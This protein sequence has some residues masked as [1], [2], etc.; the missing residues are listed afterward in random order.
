M[1]FTIDNDLLSNPKHAVNFFALLGCASIYTHVN[2]NVKSVVTGVLPNGNHVRYME[3]DNRT[4]GMEA[5]E[6][7]IASAKFKEWYPSLIATSNALPYLELHFHLSVY[8]EYIYEF[9][10]GV[11]GVGII[12]WHEG[13]YFSLEMSPKTLG[14]F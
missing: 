13:K 9:A 1:F 3:L 2:S 12:F 10:L 7:D 11:N 6:V 4:E 5:T 14:N 8:R